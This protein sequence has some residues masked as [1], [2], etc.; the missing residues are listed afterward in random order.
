M[1]KHLNDLNTK[2]QDKNLLNTDKYHAVGGFHGRR[3]LWK[4]QFRKGSVDWESFPTLTS[5]AS[6]P[7]S[8][9]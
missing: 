9:E 2:L 8:E 3:E 6:D 7:E 4:S 5:R 1:L